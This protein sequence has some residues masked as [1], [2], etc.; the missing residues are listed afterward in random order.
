MPFPKAIITKP[1]LI[2]DSEYKDLG[3]NINLVGYDSFNQVAENTKQHVSPRLL[4]WVEPYEISGERKTLFYTEVNTNFQ[5]GD[6]VYIVNGNYDND[7]LIKKD[8]YKKGR[9]GYK[10]LK[11]DNCKIV[12]DIDYT[13]VLPYNNDSFDD[14]IKIYYIDND[15]KFL[16]AN[17]QITTRGGKFD[18]KFNYYQNNIAFIDKDLK[19]ID[20]W[21]LNAGVSGTPGFFVREERQGWSKI[22]DE[23]IYLGSFSVA[24]SPTYSNNGKMIVMDGSFTYNGIQFKEGF[25]YR[26]VVGP[27]SYTH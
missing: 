6:R 13:G 23:L 12:L 14:Y 21:G 11:M 7:S 3:L 22:S 4:N 18:Y 9:D 17:R 19:G 25:V 20:G 5:V 16:N 2:S 26:W 10:V 1:L 24:L 8:K 15:E 27:V